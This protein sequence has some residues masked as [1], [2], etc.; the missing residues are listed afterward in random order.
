MG[1]NVDGRREVKE[2]SSGTFSDGS[3]LDVDGRRAVKERSSGTF[4]DG[5]RLVVPRMSDRLGAA[6]NMVFWTKNGVTE[7]YTPD[8]VK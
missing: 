4:S 2:R 3:L 6:R 5:S 8:V 7:R 1:E